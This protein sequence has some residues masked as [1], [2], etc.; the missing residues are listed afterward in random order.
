[1]RVRG[2]FAAWRAAERALADAEAGVAA[3]RRDEEW[4]RHAAAELDRLAPE[5][6]EE[7]RLDRLRRHLQAAER[8]AEALASAR[9]ELS[10]N[11]GVAQALRSASRALER[12]GPDDAVAPVLGALAGAQDAVAEAETLLERLLADAAPDPR[13]LEAAEERLFA[14]RAAARKHRVAVA[15]L[16]G[17]REQLRERLRDLDLGEQRIAALAEAAAAAR[18]AYRQAADRLA[19]ARR[20]AAEALAQAV[21][22][23]LAPLRLE[24][25]RFVAEI[26][27]RD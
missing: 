16:P 10:R 6:D 7:E 2:A 22:R 25:A 19:T 18:A 9:D 27:R 20:Q 12:L 14:L 3:A 24:R 15:D 5:T 11:R 23:E 4:L 1:E 13:A 8:R 17:L 21:A 26:L